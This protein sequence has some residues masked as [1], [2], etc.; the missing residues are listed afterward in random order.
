MGR[1]Q[2]TQLN[3]KADEVK[4]YKKADQKQPSPAKGRI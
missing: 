3:R 4:I 1:L 2:Q